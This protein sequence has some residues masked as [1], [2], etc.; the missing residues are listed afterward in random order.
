MRGR[1]GGSVDRDAGLAE[2]GRQMHRPAIHA[3]DR[4]SAPRGI[5]QSLDAGQMDARAPDSSKDLPGVE[6]AVDD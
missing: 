3:D 4:L 5:Y 2:R 1:I 6:R